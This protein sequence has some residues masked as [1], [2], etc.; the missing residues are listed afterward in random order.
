MPVGDDESSMVALCTDWVTR[1][2]M[3]A[4]L[5]ENA[6]IAPVTRKT[7]S[8]SI[9]AYSTVVP[10]DRRAARSLSRRRNISP[11]ITMVPVRP[12]CNYVRTGNG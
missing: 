11:A 7:T 3:D 6:T 2:D 4:A 9:T 1:S 12:V 8:E 5:V 10:A